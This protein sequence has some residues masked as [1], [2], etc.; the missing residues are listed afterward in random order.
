MKLKIEDLANSTF[1]YEG[2]AGLWTKILINC[3]VDLQSKYPWERDY[4]KQFIFDKDNEFFD[5]VAHHLN[6]SPES[7]REGIAKRVGMSHNKGK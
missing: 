3:I 2:I 7:L 4:A 1:Q 5:Y 6:C